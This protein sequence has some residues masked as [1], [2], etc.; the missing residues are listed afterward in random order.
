MNPAA[1]KDHLKSE[2]YSLDKQES[3]AEKLKRQLGELKRRADKYFEDLDN[4]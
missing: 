3:T 2:S 1:F 4:V